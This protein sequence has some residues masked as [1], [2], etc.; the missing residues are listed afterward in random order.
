MTSQA[1]AMQTTYNF[2][3]QELEALQAAALETCQG[4]E[5]GEAQPGAP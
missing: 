3:Q 2:S 4:I 1:E 5:E